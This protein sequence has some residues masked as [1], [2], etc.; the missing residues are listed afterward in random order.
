VDDF[1]SAARWRAL[2]CLALVL[3]SAGAWAMD[4]RV[5]IDLVHSKTL[6]PVQFEGLRELHLILDTGMGFDGLLLFKPGLKDSLGI[7][8]LI[9]A[10]IPGAGGG[11]PSDAF[12]ADSVGFR[13]GGVRVE[14]Q[15]I[16]ILSESSMGSAA[17]DGVIGYSLLGHYAV[18]VDFD[19]LTL[20]LRDPQAF[21][22]A[23]GWT[24][25]PL[26]FGENNLPFLETSI[27]VEREAPVPLKT[28]ID[29]ASSEAIEL[30][31]RDDMKFTLPQQTTEAYLGRGLSGDIHGQRGT[32]AKLILG[33]YELQDVV[34]AFVPAQIRSKAGGADAV[35]ANAALC[36]FNL[37]FDYAHA[38]LLLRPN[39]HFAERFE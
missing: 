11:P 4:P 22:P 24:S 6:V 1:G 38:R 5:P 15:R 3:V 28:Y 8:N 29:C 19:S 30:L 14:N 36:R 34:A 20:A 37:V 21:E 10:K 9:A 39:S 31:L 17:V 13:V 2:L 23:P 26:T 35:L 25:V 33:P 18:E 16:I 7:R 12:F 32:L 27:V